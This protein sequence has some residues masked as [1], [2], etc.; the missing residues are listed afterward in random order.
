MVCGARAGLTNSF[1]AHASAYLRSDNFVF[2][3]ERKYATLFLTDSLSLTKVHSNGRGRQ[4][5]VGR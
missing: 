5:F 1:C 3:M 2:S 4:L